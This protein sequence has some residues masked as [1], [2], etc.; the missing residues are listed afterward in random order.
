MCPFAFPTPTSCL[1]QARRILSFLFWLPALALITLSAVNRASAASLPAG[2]TE[3]PIG[4]GW[5]EVV[6]LTFAPD[7]RMYAWERGG[8][9][10]IVENGV[11]SATPFIDISE[12]VGAWRDFGLLGFCLHPDFVHNGYVYLLYMVDH[13]YLKYFGTAD[14]SP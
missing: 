9:V 2:F 6:G 10:W 1:F 3:T 8:K 7:G 12:E 4:S 11:K 14:Y 13:H 5:T